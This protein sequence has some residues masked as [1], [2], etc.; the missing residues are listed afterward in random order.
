LAAK[1]NE[2]VSRELVSELRIERIDVLASDRLVISAAKLLDAKGRPVLGLRGLTA[3]LDA[4]TLI[5]NLLEPTARVELKDV[6]IDRFELGLYH[7]E[8]GGVTLTEAFDPRLDPA[9]P[10]ASSKAGKGPRVL[11]PRVAIDRLDVRTDLSGLA[12]ATAELRALNFKFEWSPDL[13]ALGLVTEDARISRVLPLEARLRLNGQLRIPGTTDLTLD[14]SVGDSQIQ[15]S[16]RATEDELALSLSTPSL[17]PEAMRTLISGWPLVVPLSAHVQLAGRPSAMHAKAEVSA[18]A[19]RLD[20]EGPVALS[21]SVKGELSVKASALDARLLAS[22]LAQ[23]A[24]NADAKL[25]FALDS[26][27]HVALSAHSAKSDWLGTPLPETNI[28][29]A[30][31]DDQITGTVTC[32]DPALPASLDFRVSPERTLGFHAH[33]QNLDLAALAAYGLR[34]QGQADLDARGELKKQQV[35]V[36]FEGRIRALRMASVVVQSALLRGKLSGSITRPA[37]L[38]VELEAQGTKFALGAVEF[39]TW[40]VESKGSFQRQLVSVR[41]GPET[42]PTLQAS[43]TLILSEGVSLSDT[44]LEADLHGVKHDVELKRTRIAADALELT[45]LDWR[46]GAGSISGSVRISPAHRLAD[47]EVSELQP[48]ALLKSLGIDDQALQGRVAARLHFEEA[49]RHRRGRLTGSLANGQLPAVG[50][51]EAQ[52]DVGI[53]DS[54][55]EGQGSLRAPELG[56]VKLSLRGSLGHTPIDSQ[57]LSRMLGELRVDLSDLELAEV[58]RRWLPVR[59]I[60]LSGRADA[61]V[62]LT[63]TEPSASPTLSYALKTHGL[64][65]RSQGARDESSVRDGEISSQG[66]I[67]ARETR[68]EVELNDAAGAWVSANVQHSLGLTEMLHALRSSSLASLIDAPI[69][70]SISA[71]PRSLELLGAGVPRAFSGEVAARLAVKGSLRRPDLEGSLSATGLGSPGPDANGKLALTFDYSAEREQYSVSARYAAREHAKLEFNGGG[72]WSWLERGFGREW[73]ARGEGKIEKIELGPVGEFLAVPLTGE[74][75]G[76]I[77][78]SASSSEFEASGKLDL[79]RLSLDRHSLGDGNV[80]LRVREGLAEAQLSLDRGDAT[81]EVASEIGLCWDAGPCIDAK[82]GGSLD[83]KVRNFQLAALAPLLRSAVSDIR[84]PVNGFM[85]LAWDPADASGKRNTRVRADAVVSNGS[86]T[87]TSG[88]GS[89]QC[90]ALRARGDEQRTLNLDVSG[91]ARSSKPNLDARVRVLWNGPTPERVEADL[92]QLKEVPVTFDGVM[93]GKASVPKNQPIRLRLDLAKTQRAVEVNL[94]ALE[95][96]LPEKD[97]TRLVELEDDPAIFV[98]DA[99]VPPSREADAEEESPWSVS[100]KLGSAVKVTQ[101]G[102]KVPVTGALTQTPDGLLEG[103]LTLPEGGVVPQLG[104]IFRLKRSSVHFNHQALKDGALNIEAST[105]TAE[106]IVVDLIVSGTIEKPVIRLR[107]DP[108]RS[109]NDI[110]ALLLGVQGSDTVNS[111]GKQGADLRG[112]ATALAMNQLLRGSKLAGLQFGAGQTHQGD[113]VSTVSMRAADTVWFEART[114]RSSTQRAANSGVQSSGVIDWRFAR[115]FSLRTQL[116]T[117]SGLE[118][119][120]SHRY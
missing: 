66:E 116:G 23:T 6:H 9:Q 108:P 120:W 103:T 65:L 99:K 107:S 97:D 36:D 98:A 40:S 46:V 28:A 50:A 11:L 59:G 91:C 60:A 3:R 45:G 70:A 14:G 48:Q 93:L 47:L 74:V 111:S 44:Q 22:D 95:F 52:L 63:K 55:V 73:S 16:L 10:K 110:I 72:H 56:R 13:L 109:E 84:G 69:H 12:Q 117:I 42:A 83:A 37:Q 71:R 82:R 35:T 25:E 105:R 76:Q 100:V 92:G 89:L 67:G 80:A 51:I 101:P 94:P 102:M 21:P 113:S 118:L 62:R 26:A 68:L 17:T 114:V 90:L 88:A 81:L 43:T 49:G 78:L 77:A 53:A 20:A 61:S 54:E 58:S 38:G 29:A 30:F 96:A 87:L 119:R 34:G 33:A 24:L 64:Q 41:A 5:K 18:G 8:S 86:V 39:P 75:A 106:G 32:L 115:G 7:S 57:A 85:T 19:S 1:V 112:S 31:A 2:W 79:R 27:I 104:Q 15:G 4:W